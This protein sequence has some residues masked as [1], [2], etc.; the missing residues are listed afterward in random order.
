MDFEDEE[1]IEAWWK[2]SED[3]M[4]DTVSEEQSQHEMQPSW[5][6]DLVKQP[7]KSEV[8]DDDW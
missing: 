2:D 7:S 4:P 1:T 5:M 3:S 8:S 6:N